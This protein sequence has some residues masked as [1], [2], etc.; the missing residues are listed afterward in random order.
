M[1]AKRYLLRYE[2]DNYY[3]NDNTMGIGIMLMKHEILQETEK[4]YLIS[5]YGVKTKRV[6]KGYK[7]SYAFIDKESAFNNFKYR[8]KRSLSICKNNYH[9]AKQ[10]Y[11]KY[12]NLKLDEI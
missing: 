12:F 1:E 2:R 10:Y 8:T 6:I 3:I 4:S 9:L 7:G 11:E 5:L